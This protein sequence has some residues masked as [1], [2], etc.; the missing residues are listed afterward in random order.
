[1]SVCH[2]VTPTYVIFDIFWLS[3]RLYPCQSECWKWQNK[4]LLWCQQY[5]FPSPN[6]QTYHACLA[7]SKWKLLDLINSFLSY[8]CMLNIFF[9]GV[10][11]SLCG[12]PW[13]NMHYTTAKVI[14]VF[15]VQDIMNRSIMNMFLLMKANV[16]WN[17]PIKMF[18]KCIHCWLLKCLIHLD[19]SVCWPPANYVS[20][21]HLSDPSDCI[22]L[23]PLLCLISFAL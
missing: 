21:M 14:L 7:S 3:R 5:I 2:V 18:W 10:D 23:S 4:V 8:R 16:Y 9:R 15:H 13:Y 12:H 11:R 19:C 20:S 22:N 6:I 1:V 17:G